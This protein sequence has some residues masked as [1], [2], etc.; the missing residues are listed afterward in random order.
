MAAAGYG[1]GGK[2]DSSSLTCD[3]DFKFLS[4]NFLTVMDSVASVG[5][6]K[7]VPNLRDEMDTLASAL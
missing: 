5:R 7:S 4:T 6:P 1:P 2:V 3:H